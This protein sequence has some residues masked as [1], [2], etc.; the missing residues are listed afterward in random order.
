MSPPLDPKLLG[1]I[2]HDLRSPLNVIQLSTRMIDQTQVIDRADL[3]EDL[4]MLRQNALHLELML[5]HL[6]DYCRQYE[7]EKLA[8]SMRF[9]TERLVLDVIDT[10][11]ESATNGQA[12]KT[13]TIELTQTAPRE[14]ELDLQRA[15]LALSLALRNAWIATPHGNIRIVVDGSGD[16]VEIRVISEGVTKESSPPEMLR[17]DS[18]ERLLAIAAERRAVDLAIVARISELFGGSA[19]L[20]R[21]PGRSSSIILDW[22]VRLGEE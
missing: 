14:L 9:G 13:V 16:R 22:P 3:D 8:A 10:E 21:E 11:R 12:K 20:E 5:Q 4:S 1:T 18:F 19:R 15:R 6:G 2:V 7:T 17:G